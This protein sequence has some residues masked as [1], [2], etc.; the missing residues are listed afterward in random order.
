MR[1]LSP[2]AKLLPPS[3]LSSIVVESAAR[4]E[5]DPVGHLLDPQSSLSHLLSHGTTPVSINQ[6]E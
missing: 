1:M 5:N 4:F 6:S 3:V 2:L